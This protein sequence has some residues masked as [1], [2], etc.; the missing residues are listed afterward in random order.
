MRRRC[1]ICVGRYKKETE[2]GQHTNSRNPVFDQTL[3][4]I[5]DADTAADPHTHISLD[6]HDKH[7][8]FPAD[9]KVPVGWHHTAPLLAFTLGMA[10]SPGWQGCPINNRPTALPAGVK[11]QCAMPHATRVPNDGGCALHVLCAGAGSNPAEP[12][13]PAS[14]HA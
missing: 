6:I 7:F 8:L 12:G 4:F 2:R 9:F 1:K 13:H 10:N 11:R 3:E 14:A 5:L